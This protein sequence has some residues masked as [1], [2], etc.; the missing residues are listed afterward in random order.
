M[1]VAFGDVLVLERGAS[2]LGITVGSIVADRLV[3]VLPGRL[4]FGRPLVLV[5]K[6]GEARTSLELVPGDAY[7]FAEASGDARP[8][9]TLP[10][11]LVDAFVA[12]VKGPGRY[13]LSPE[14][15]VTVVDTPIRA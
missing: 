2:G 7:A 1:G 6:S 4:R 15:S 10:P 12:M 9:L 8:K 5:G 3:T 11:A 14:L 13:A